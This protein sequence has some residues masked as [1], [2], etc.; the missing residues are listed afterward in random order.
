MSIYSELGPAML[1]EAQNRCDKI[2]LVSSIL[3]AGA[4]W[5]LGGAKQVLGTS[6]LAGTAGILLHA[7]MPM[8]S[9]E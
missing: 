3:G 7:V 5:Y 2:W 8:P 9:E 6:A 4:G 1:A